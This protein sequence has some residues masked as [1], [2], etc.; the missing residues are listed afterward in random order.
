M[1]MPIQSLM[2]MEMALY[3][4]LGA[5][6]SAPSMYNNYR[7]GNLYNTP[8]YN[9]ATPSFQGYN[10]G[11]SFGQNIPSQYQTNSTAE[12]QF[13]NIFAG[14][15]KDEQSALVDDYAKGLSPSESFKSAVIGATAFSVLF[16]PRAIVHPFNT[17]NSFKMTKETFA[18]LTKKGSK[19]A[20]AY[21]T[22]KYNEILRDAYTAMNRIDARS[23][24]T[25]SIHIWR[26]PL[27][28]GEYKN[29]KD[30]MTKAVKNFNAAD[31]NSVKELIRATETLNQANVKNGLFG[32][33]GNGISNIVRRIKGQPTVKLTA[34]DAVAR[35]KNTIEES[36][37]KVSDSL[38]NIKIEKGKSYGKVLKTSGGGVKGGIF[39]LAIEYLT[40]MGKIK[41]CF[42]KDKKTGFK[43]LG[44]TTVKGIGSAAGWAAGE[45][46]GV[47]GCTKLL[48]AAGTAIAPGIGTAIGAVAG[49]IVG[50]IGCW[51]A[52]KITNKLVGQD[53]GDKVQAEN[54]AKTQEGQ[55]QL[56]QYTM[57]K[58][59]K[60]EAVDP[61]SKLAVQKVINQYA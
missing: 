41:D 49:M 50:S 11:A 59:Q 56:L 51:L 9:Y 15:S 55:T 12:N 39:F 3:G 14:L 31:E 42:K 1:V 17:K 34:T 52:G 32:K 6:S 8:Y 61:K 48:A 19:L 46:L 33:I 25:K 45:A 24:K 29:L 16:H 23:L 38:K 20:E 4:G 54:L 30:I 43:Q 40:S 27:Q 60:G 44:Q 13:N 26:A 58:I 5:N 2:N 21:A 53:I 35:G 22:P 18:D 37:T 7:T 47:W 36:V 57:E 28:E 10:Y